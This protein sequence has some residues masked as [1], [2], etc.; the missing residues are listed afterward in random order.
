MR[1]KVRQHLPSQPKSETPSACQFCFLTRTVA[2]SS[3]APAVSTGSVGSGGR[4]ADDKPS[5]WNPKHLPPDKD[6]KGEIA[7]IKL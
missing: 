5:P 6:G 4:S 3:A 2:S 1:F 7:S